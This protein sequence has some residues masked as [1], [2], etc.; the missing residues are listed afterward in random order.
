VHKQINKSSL[1]VRK[2]KVIRKQY[3]RKSRKCVGSD[4]SGSPS[5]WP[6]QQMKEQISILYNLS[7]I[8]ESHLPLSDLWLFQKFHK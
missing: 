1:Y 5:C 4:D 8:F 7:Y 3:F 2:R 6:A